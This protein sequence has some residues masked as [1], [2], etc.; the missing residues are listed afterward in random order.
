MADSAPAKLA[1]IL[2]QARVLPPADRAA[3]LRRAC[4][5]DEKLRTEA[6]ARLADTDNEWWHRV[7][8]FGGRGE[9]YAGTEVDWSRSEFGPYRGI[10]MKWFWPSAAINFDKESP[11]SLLEEDCFRAMRVCDY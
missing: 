5:N 1:E 4:G 7:D 6:E 3:F 8:V 9:E 2:L 11:S 10:R